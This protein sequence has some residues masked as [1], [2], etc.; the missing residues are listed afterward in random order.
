MQVD[1]VLI[2]RVKAASRSEREA[3]DSES[4]SHQQWRQ[5]CREVADLIDALP[6]PPPKLLPCPWCEKTDELTI[7]LPETDDEY[8]RCSR[9]DMNG[10]RGGIAAWNNRPATPKHLA[11]PA[12][13]PEPAKKINPC[14]FCGG[15]KIGVDSSVGMWCRDCGGRGPLDGR[16]FP[17]GH[18]GWNHRSHLPKGGEG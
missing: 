7:K 6:D 9:C 3:W 8:V 10:P 16:G 4:F 17:L 2:E 18:I 12:P 5:L 1:D 15:E 14:P 11:A 13:A